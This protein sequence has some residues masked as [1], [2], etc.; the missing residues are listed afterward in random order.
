MPTRGSESSSS[1]DEEHKDV[2]KMSKDERENI[3]RK[4]YENRK[5][6]EYPNNLVV[7][8]RRPTSSVV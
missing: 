4:S 8:S 3:L 5:S 1:S 2:L 6:L 7:I